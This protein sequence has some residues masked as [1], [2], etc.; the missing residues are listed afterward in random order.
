MILKKL[1]P[2]KHASLTLSLHPKIPMWVKNGNFGK[3]STQNKK[4]LPMEDQLKNAAE[5]A[6]AKAQE[7]AGEAQEKFEDLKGEITE[8]LQ[9]VDVDALKAQAMAKAEE[10]KGEATEAFEDAKVKAEE[11]AA[12]AQ[13]KFEDL[14]EDAEA[15]LG[16]AT[17]FIKGLFGGGDAK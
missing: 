2:Q 15:A 13:E 16:K 6:K 3:F 12:E 5:Q 11:F 8:R 14:R 7:L 10:L 17:G 9:E 4:I 1:R